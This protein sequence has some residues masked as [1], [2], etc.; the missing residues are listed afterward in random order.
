L[1]ALLSVKE[2]ADLRAMYLLV[3][4]MDQIFIALSLLFLPALATQFA[5][6]NIVHFLS[7]WKLF[8]VGIFGMTAIF[9]LCIRIFGAAFIHALYAGKFDGLLPILYIL[10]LAPL[11]M[12]IGTSLSSALKS[13][14]NPRAVFYAFT[15]GGLMT[16]LAG[17][18]LVRRLGLTGASIGI[19][20]S[21]ATSTV[22]LALGFW[23]AIYRKLPKSR[24][25]PGLN[26]L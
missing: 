9:A 6:K 23:L 22:G 15:A 10:I 24:E 19:L 2:V 8:A 13:A 5:L 3:A 11:L 7:L 4:P 1:A 26:A 14:E 25:F 16:F 18:P 12:G 21:A 17:I 20:I